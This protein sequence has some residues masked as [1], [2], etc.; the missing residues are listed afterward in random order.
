[1]D[2]KLGHVRWLGGSA[3]AGKTSVARRLAA[4]H[5]LTLYSTDDRFADHRR[6][7]DPV[8]HSTFL[9]VGGLP[10]EELWARPAAEQAAELVLFY[11]E[12]SE[13]VV[14]DLEALP[15]PVLA[16]GVGLL[17]ELVAPRLASQAR[18][19]W[20]IATPELRRAVYPQRGPF[21]Q[22]LLSRCP[23]PQEAFARWMERDDRIAGLLADQARHLGLAVVPVDGDKDIEAVA[24]E[25]A[26]KLGLPL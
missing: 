23:D 18:A 21:V 12:E 7:A 2:G 11:K 14:E 8:R 10:P 20:L 25:V 6:R 3:A 17:P 4:A 19:V 15:G 1:M 9:R 13:M 24:A 16:E 22:E 5:G 26:W